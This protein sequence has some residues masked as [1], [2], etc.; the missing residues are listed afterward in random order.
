MVS[1][2]IKWGIGFTVLGTILGGSGLSKKMVIFH[3][4][5]RQL[6]WGLAHSRQHNYYFKKYLQPVT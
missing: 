3:Y 6:A 1:L 5:L 4:T 2:T